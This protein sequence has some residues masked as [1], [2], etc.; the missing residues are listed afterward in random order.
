MALTTESALRKDRR[1]ARTA[2][3]EHR[4]FAVVASIVENLGFLDAAQRKAVAYRFATELASTNPRFNRTRFL[5]AC[6]VEA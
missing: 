1:S 5:R 6:G 3:M 4:H 2:T